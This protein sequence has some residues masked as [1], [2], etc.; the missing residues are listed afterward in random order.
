MYVDQSV[1]TL[2]GLSRYTNKILDKIQKSDNYTTAEQCIG[3]W[4]GKPLYRAVFQVTTPKTA[5]YT[6]VAKTT[7][8]KYV[9]RVDG[10]IIYNTRQHVGVNFIDTTLTPTGGVWTWYRYGELMMHV[11]ASKYYGLQAYVILEYTKTTDRSA[12]EA[13]SLDSVASIASTASAL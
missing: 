10:F 12:D 2:A 13:F 9:V 1:L 4:L 7:D 3:T 6:A 5:T 8:N 11:S